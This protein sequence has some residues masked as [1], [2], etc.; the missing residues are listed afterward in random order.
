VWYQ[1]Q[2]VLGFNYLLSDIHCALGRSQLD[3]LDRFIAE[4]N[5]IADRYRQA[6]GDLEQIVLPPSPPPGFRHVYHLFVIRHREGTDARR[7]L[8]DGLR[9]RDVY[10]QVHYLPVYRHP[11]YQTT[12]GYQEGCARR[13]S[14][15]TRSAFRFRATRD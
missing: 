1:E 10:V 6:L 9:E 13:P 12:Y 5:L 15:T 14:A 11:F 2:I 3:K 4:R 7:R 8:F